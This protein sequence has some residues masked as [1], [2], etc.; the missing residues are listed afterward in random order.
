[1]SDDERSVPLNHAPTDRVPKER[2]PDALVVAE[3]FGPTFQGEGPTTGERAGFVRL[4]RCNLTCAW[5]DTPFTWDW[6]RFDPSIELRNL[7]VDDVLERVDAME[8]GRVIV[9]GGE[10]LL[11]QRRLLPLL[12][13]LRERGLMVEIETNATI[14]PVPELPAA[15]DRL[16]VSPKLAN[17][18][19]PP[20]RRLVPDALEAFRACGKSVFKFVVEGPGDL[21]EVQHLVHRFDLQPVWIMPEATTVE[22]LT[23]GLRDLADEVLARKWN[24]T[25]RLHVS[26]WDDVRGR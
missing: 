4:G 26:L 13:E 10:P 18:G 14:V 23:R 8:V 20:A 25:S 1:M 11:Q 9:T 22:G 2:A 19:V 24:L 3:V 17:S 5:C 6:D 16:N 15:V 21:D 12:N 7:S